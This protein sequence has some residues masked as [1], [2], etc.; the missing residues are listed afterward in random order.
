MNKVCRVCLSENV[1]EKLSLDTIIDK[2]SVAELITYCSGI[3]VKFFIY[4]FNVIFES[5]TY[6]FIKYF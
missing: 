6:I 5:H 3:E 2:R 1:E 4:E